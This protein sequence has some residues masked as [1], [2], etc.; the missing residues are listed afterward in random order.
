M[1]NLSP[2]ISEVERGEFIS[3][4]EILSANAVE[5]SANLRDISTDLNSPT[6]IIMLQQTL[7]SARATFENVQK[8]TS[9]LDDI[10]GDERF[11]RSLKQIINGLGDLFSSTKQLEQQTR[12]AKNIEILLKESSSSE[13]SKSTESN[14]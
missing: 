4:L 12:M 9:D 2:I 14:E 13:I 7:D 1:E 11:R 8:M 6:N 10:T 5:T 3:N